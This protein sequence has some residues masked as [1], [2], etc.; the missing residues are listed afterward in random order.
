[1]DGH[2][3][4]NRSC[5]FFFLSKSSVLKY[6]VLPKEDY[7]FLSTLSSPTAERPKFSK[8]LSVHCLFNLAGPQ[9]L[10]PFICFMAPPSPESDH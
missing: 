7:L 5:M 10:A 8:S 2:H 1:M 3:I 9:L 4:V 6:T